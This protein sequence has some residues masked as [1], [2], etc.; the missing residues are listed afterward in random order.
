MIPQKKKKLA[1]MKLGI[2]RIIEKATMM[3]CPSEYA[4]MNGL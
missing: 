3:V 4:V 2:G 1:P